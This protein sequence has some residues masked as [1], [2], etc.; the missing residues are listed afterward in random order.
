MSSLP[1]SHRVPGHRV[2]RDARALRERGVSFPRAVALARRRRPRTFS[3]AYAEELFQAL[4]DATAHEVGRWMAEGGTLAA[5]PRLV[6]RRTA[7]R[8]RGAGRPR[9]RRTRSRSRAGPSSDDDPDLPAPAPRRREPPPPPP[10]RRYRPRPIQ[11][12]RDWLDWPSERLGA[13]RL[14]YAT[15][16][17]A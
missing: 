12:R 10:S 2:V 17:P 16:R 11:P 6:Q 1:A 9:T 15:R 5:P 8:A 13:F 14:S 4:H 7:P 3:A